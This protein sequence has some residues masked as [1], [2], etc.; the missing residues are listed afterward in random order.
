MSFGNWRAR[1]VDA[2]GQRLIVVGGTMLLV[3]LAAAPGA[4][5][6]WVVWFAFR[7][8]LGHAAIVL[9]AAVCAVVMLVEVM[10]VTEAIGPAYERLDLLSVERGD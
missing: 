6:G 8:V 5:L 2:V 4:A 9:A 7:R 1:G 3:A 10:F